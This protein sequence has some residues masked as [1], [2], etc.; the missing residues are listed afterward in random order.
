MLTPEGQLVA[1]LDTAPDQGYSP[2]SRLP[3][4]PELIERA[5][6]QLPES[7]APGRYLLIAGLYNPDLPGAPRLAAANGRDFV[8]LGIVQIR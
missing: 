7:L 1:L 4:G 8:E 5:A 6:L 3:S 2:F